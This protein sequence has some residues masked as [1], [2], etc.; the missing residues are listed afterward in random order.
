V[1]LHENG[2]PG[3]V[4][5]TCE[6]LRGRTSGALAQRRRR[7]LDRDRVQVHHGV[8]RVVRV[9]HRDPVDQRAEVVA[10]VQ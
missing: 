2:G 4:H 10:K 6:V 7:N 9:L 8:E 3:G 1:A 5:P